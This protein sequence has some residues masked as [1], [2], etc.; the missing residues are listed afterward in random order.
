MKKH[1]EGYALVFVLV[2]MAVLGI[3]A[4]TLMTGAMKN[5]QAQNTSLFQMQ[6]KYK[7][8]GEIEKAIQVIRTEPRINSQTQQNEYTIYNILLGEYGPNGQYIPGVRDAIDGI[9]DGVEWV[10]EVDNTGKTIL[11]WK[12]SKSCL[13]SLRAT[14]PGVLIECTVVLKNAVNSEGLPVEIEYESYHI[15]YMDTSATEGGAVE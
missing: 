15:E 6:A 8:Q 14:K 3:V 11:K 5:L 10:V 1:D 4:T 2:V 13:I 7:A 9:T 12:D